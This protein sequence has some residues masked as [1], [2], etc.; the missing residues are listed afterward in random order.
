MKKWKSIL[1]LIIMVSVLFG[2]TCITVTADVDQDQVFIDEEGT[3]YDRGDIEAFNEL[4]KYYGLDGSKVWVNRPSVWSNFEI[5]EWSKE[6][7][8]RLEVLR[9][10]RPIASDSPGPT[11][12]Q[13]EGNVVISGLTALKRIDLATYDS[14]SMGTPTSIVLKDLFSLETVEISPGSQGNWKTLTI[15]NTPN[16]MKLDVS[17]YNKLKKLSCDSSRLKTVD[18]SGCDLEELCLD[19]ALELTSLDCSYNQKLKKLT[20]NSPELISLNCRTDNLAELDVSRCPKL[21]FLDCTSNKLPV[22]NIS[23]NTELNELRCG[24][25]QLKE[26]DVSRNTLL[27]KLD[28]NMNQ[29]LRKLKVSGA[30]LKSLICM[31]NR[32]SE[33]DLSKNLGLTYLNCSYNHLT[34]LDVSKHS[35]L[36]YLDCSYNQLTKLDLSRNTLLKSYFYQGNPLSS[37]I[38]PGEILPTGITIS[39]STA[40]VSKGKQLKLNAVLTPAK[41]SNKTVK[42]RSSNTSIATVNSA[43][44]VTAKKRGTAVITAA[45]VRKPGLYK[46]CRVTVKV[47]AARII[48]SSKEYI[49]K[50][51]TRSLYA[52]LTPSDTTDKITW[53]SSNKKV[54]QVNTKGKVK[55]LKTGTATITAKTSSG[56][57]DTCKVKIVK[58]TVKTKKIKIS[59]KAIS[60]KKG[61]T[62]IL[63]VTTSPSYATDTRT[64]K[65]SKP[66]VAKVDKNGVVTAIKKGKAVITVKTSSGKKV[67]CKVTVK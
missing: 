66:S 51:K 6:E 10:S 26:L 59:K 24:V 39:R 50:G 63:K 42:W 52:T 38:K 33:L 56:K 14:Q 30:P 18:V 20:L 45:S 4:L 64:F 13:M 11:G 67:T 53:S 23:K 40:S 15:A 12:P 17:G 22:L 60:I 34:K 36:T 54:A 55:G 5:V 3:Q 44:L 48:I 41:T 47:P 27:T 19:Q 65:S 25:N 37:V 49:K 46:T 8:K 1:A 61:K 29:E 57:K 28:T 2:S 31:D 35:K 9:L 62:L 43:G 32:L 7:P 21:T 16:L 58:K